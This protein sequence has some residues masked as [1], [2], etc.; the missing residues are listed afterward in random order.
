MSLKSILK[1]S[2]QGYPWHA[3]MTREKYTEA[4]KA[5]DETFSRIVKNKTKTNWDMALLLADIVERGLYRAYYDEYGNKCS[6]NTFTS[7]K[8]S[9]GRYD[10]S[11]IEKVEQGL[12]YPIPNKDI[13]LPRFGGVHNNV[14]TNVPINKIQDIGRY[15]LKRRHHHYIQKYVK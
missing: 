6:V 10:I 9:N 12:V 14:I 7:I 4:F 13:T 1:E 5:A 2:V 11:K 3:N 15:E 8:K